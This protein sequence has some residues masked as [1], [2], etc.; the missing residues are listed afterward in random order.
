MGNLEKLGILVIVILVVVVGVVAITPKSTVD[1]RLMQQPEMAAAEGVEPLDPAAPGATDPAQAPVDPFPVAGSDATRLPANSLDPVAPPAEAAAFRL[2]KA[3]ANDTFAT[4]AKRELTTAARFTEIAKLNPELNGAK[5]KKGQDVKVPL[6][7]P[8]ATG[9]DAKSAGTAPDAG[10]SNVPAPSTRTYTVRS[11][12]TLSSIAQR[13][14]R[15]RNRW[16]ELQQANEDVL[17]GTTNLKIGMKLRIPGGETASQTSLDIASP[18]T[19]GTAPAA[20]G[21]EREY[22]VKSGDSLWLIAKNELGSERHLSALREANS[23]V[24]KGGDSLKVG[25]KLRLPSTQ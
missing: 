12:D 2:V 21:G 4:I 22:V 8:P 16:K 18:A 14:L 25:M 13:E 7:P 6:A 11:G 15:S 24:L 17:H 3:Q 1:E 23:D 10:K 19:A 20:T 9:A 5:L